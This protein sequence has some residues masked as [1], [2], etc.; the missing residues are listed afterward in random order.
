[1][2]S[3]VVVNQ[4]CPHIDSYLIC[5]FFYC[6][7]EFRSFKTKIPISAKDNVHSSPMS[8]AKIICQSDD[9]DGR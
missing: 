5:S 1:M 2:N 6:N 4:T 7:S 9:M 8:K 3:L